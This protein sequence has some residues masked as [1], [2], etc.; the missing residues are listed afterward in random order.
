MNAS[1]SIVGQVDLMTILIKILWVLLISVSTG[2]ITYRMSK[3]NRNGF[4]S[5]ILLSLTVMVVI[6]VVK[7]SL[8][9]SLGMV[10][11]LS[12]VRFR[13][14]V[15]E[16]E[17]L[18]F[19]FMSIVIG[20]GVG[21]DQEKF[22]VFLGIVYLVVLYFFNLKNRENIDQRGGFV[23]LVFNRRLNMDLFIEEALDLGISEKSITSI[24]VT[25]IRSEVVLDFD[26]SLKKADSSKNWLKNLN[27]LGSDE[28][29]YSYV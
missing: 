8:A 6:A 22:V 24:N 2:Y 13:T 27:R 10:G 11:A 9:L 23:R 12:I 19:L 14:A 15:K 7:T 26:Y 20:I 29:F 16:I 1:E 25:D 28:I 21:A 4:Q 17:D 5:F 18:I 3:I